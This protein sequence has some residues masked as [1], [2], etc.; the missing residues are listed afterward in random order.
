MGNENSSAENQVSVTV[1]ALLFPAAQE[2]TLQKSVHGPFASHSS[3][4]PSYTRI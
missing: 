4:A 3:S 2:Q 1:I